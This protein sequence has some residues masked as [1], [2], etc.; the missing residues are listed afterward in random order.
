MVGCAIVFFG[1]IGSVGVSLLPG[2]YDRVQTG[3]LPTGVAMMVIGVFGIPTL[4][5]AV[6]SLIA[7]IRDTVRPPLLRVTA[8]GLVLPF[9]A[10]GDPPLDEYGEPISHEPPQP[11]AIPFSAIRSISRGGPRFNEVLE[12]KHELCAL[13][14]VLKQHMMRTADFDD[15]EMVLRAAVPAAFSVPQLPAPSPSANGDSHR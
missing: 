6:W 14:L 7:G 13:P 11:K 10:R 5:M 4:G 3:D 12:V 9:E 8:T 2:G 1:L 15:L